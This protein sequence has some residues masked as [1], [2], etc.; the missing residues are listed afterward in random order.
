[1]SGSGGGTSSSSGEGIGSSLQGIGSFLIDLFGANSSQNSTTNSNQTQTVTGTN[2]QTGTANPLLQNLLTAFSKTATG[3]AE[4]NSVT[5]NLV[6]NIFRQAK[7]AFAPVSQQANSS[8]IYGGSTLFDLGANAQA[9]AVGQAAQAVLGYKTTEQQLAT[10]DITSLLPYTSTSV[11]TPN[12]TTKAAGTSTTQ[13]QGNA[14]GVL[15]SV[16]CTALMRDGIIDRK[17]WYD[18]VVKFRQGW[19]WG[20][21]GYYL[22][23]IPVTCWLVKR[24]NRKTL[25]Y[26]LIARIFKK[27]TQFVVGSKYTAEGL[28][29]TLLIILLSGILTPFAQLS[30]YL[31][32]RSDNSSNSS[33]NINNGVVEDV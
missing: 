16:I 8:G 10:S 23:A 30:M 20:I 32:S 2:T 31:S 6:Q 13:A 17:D 11:T 15:G 21:P 29:Y 26:W 19:Q 1:M 5:N 18:S 14:G 22:F 28:F 25:R 4:D 27:R 7:I 24:E 9:A 12:I 33:S 3:N